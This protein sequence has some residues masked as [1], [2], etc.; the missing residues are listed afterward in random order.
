M[1]ILEVSDHA[2]CFSCMI[3]NDGVTCKGRH[4]ASFI[5]YSSSWR[6]QTEWTPCIKRTAHRQMEFCKL[7]KG[8]LHGVQMGA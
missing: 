8:Q 3:R 1:L 4:G 6:H 5:P 7:L 2:T